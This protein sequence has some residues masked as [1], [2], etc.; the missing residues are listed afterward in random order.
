MEKEQIYKLI[1]FCDNVELLDNLLEDQ[2]INNNYIYLKYNIAKNQKASPKMLIKLFEENND[3]I[4]LLMAIGKNPNSP[5]EILEKLI[6]SN[7]WKIR[8]A[9]ASNKN[10]S[11][12]LLEVLSEDDDSD[13]LGSVAKNINSPRWV[14]NKLSYNE[15]TFVSNLA[16]SNPKIQKNIAKKNKIDRKR[17]NNDLSSISMCDLIS[18]AKDKND[19]VRLSLSNNLTTPSLILSILSL[20]DV[21]EIR[22]N[23]ILNPNYTSVGFDDFEW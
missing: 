15:N 2:D 21:K 1:E 22:D 6:K 9:V 17:L 3:S 23:A 5:N 4:L 18:L 19:S 10:I 11:P 13:V 16:K 8:E 7:D 14:L 12:A 20:D